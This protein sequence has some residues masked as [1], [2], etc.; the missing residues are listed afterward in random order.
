[1]NTHILYKKGQRSRT[2]KGAGGGGHQSLP[3]VVWPALVC[4]LVAPLE[5]GRPIGETGD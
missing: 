4:H 1:M 2:T 3:R 5:H